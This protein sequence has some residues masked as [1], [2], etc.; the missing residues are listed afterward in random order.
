MADISRPED[1]TKIPRELKIVR[2]KGEK[3]AR[4][5]IDGEYFPFATVDG[6]STHPQ[7]NQM[8]CVIVSLV[9]WTVKVEDE[10]FA[11][12]DTLEFGRI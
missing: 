4:L 8:P 9:A 5:Y 3:S 2:R 12:D 10:M 11:G 7:K 6:F 1:F